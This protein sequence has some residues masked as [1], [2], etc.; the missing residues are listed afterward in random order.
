[1]RA[2]LLSDVLWATQKLGTPYPP[3]ESLSW[4]RISNASG[5]LDAELFS[6]SHGKPR[7]TETGVGSSGTLQGDSSRSEDINAMTYRLWVANGVS[8]KVGNLGS[9]AWA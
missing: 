1:M 6:L 2:A 5:E 8:V 3:Q 9:H 7:Y 4:V